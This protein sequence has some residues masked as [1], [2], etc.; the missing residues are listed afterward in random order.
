VADHPGQ[1]QVNQ[2]EWESADN[3]TLPVG[4][5][6]SKRDSRW[7]V[8]RKNPALGWTFNL[9]TSKGAWALLASFLIPILILTAT[10]LAIVFAH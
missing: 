9:G 7:L 6:F 4:F 3:W 5:Y 8:P 10:L 2:R 1:P